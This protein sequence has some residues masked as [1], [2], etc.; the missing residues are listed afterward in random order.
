MAAADG[1]DQGG[2]GAPGRRTGDAEVISE[3][4]DA[5][6]A[7]M[8]AVQ[9]PRHTIAAANAAWRPGAVAALRRAFGDWLEALGVA[10]GDRQLAELAVAEVVGNAVEH[11]YPPARPGPVRLEAAL[12]ADGFLRTRV[13]DRGRWRGPDAAAAD[14]GQG[15]SVAARRARAAAG[16]GQRAGKSRGGGPGPRRAAL[17]SAVKLTRP[18]AP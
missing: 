17:G 12:T 1:G 11:A 6:P 9:G 8:A 18:A 5:M 4:F 13:S 15:L 3:A 16:P 2:G 14:R 10:F 7:P